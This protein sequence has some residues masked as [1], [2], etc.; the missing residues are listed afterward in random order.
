MYTCL[1][2]LAL[3]EQQVAVVVVVVYMLEKQAK[4]KLLSSLFL[5][6]HKV[7]AKRFLRNA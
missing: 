7:V 6:V 3:V 4:L 2:L 5:N 1:V